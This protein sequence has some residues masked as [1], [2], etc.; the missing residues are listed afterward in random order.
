MLQEA[1]EESARADIVGEL[2]AR[3]E[4]MQSEAASSRVPV[5]YSAKLASLRL[6]RCRITVVVAALVQK[7]W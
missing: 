1:F 6:S 2:I 4:P 3:G 7:G 5:N